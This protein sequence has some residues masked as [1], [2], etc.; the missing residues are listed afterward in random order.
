MY[1]ILIVENKIEYENVFQDV[2]MSKELGSI[3]KD[4]KH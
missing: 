4:F 1:Q 3:L 2:K